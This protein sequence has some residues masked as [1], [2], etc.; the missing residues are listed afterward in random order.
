[1][2]ELVEVIFMRTSDML[3]IGKAGEYL[4]C[5]DLILKGFVAFPS[6][7]GLPFDVVMDNGKRLLR[8]QVKTTEKPR[9][10]PQRVSESNAYIFNIKRAGKNGKTRYDESDI[11]LFALVCLDTMKVGYLVAKDMPETINIRVDALKGT[12]RD[13]KGIKD[14]E[15]VKE[16]HK[17]IK[18]QS[19]IARRTGMHVSTVNRMLMDGFEPYKTSARYF[20]DFE[21]ESEWFENI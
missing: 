1:V 20:S 13:E 16:M 3:Q 9:I 7:Q 10:V 8:I 5:A 18:S 2:I 15:L 19:E 17:T 11:D 4:T 6:E 21:R 12:H 14:F